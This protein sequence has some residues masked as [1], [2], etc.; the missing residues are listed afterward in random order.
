MIDEFIER[1]GEV[2]RIFRYNPK[3]SVYFKTAKQ[4]VAILDTM[5][6]G[7]T[8]FLDG[9]LQSSERDEEI[10]HRMLVHPILGT[11]RETMKD[12]LVIGGGEG[13]TL[14]EILK[15]KD[16]GSVTMLDWDKE[17]I[18]YFREK[19][20]TWHRG[21]FEDPR[22]KLEFSDIF[23]VI[24]ET[25]KYDR[26]Y[27]DLV[28]PDLKDE[29]WRNFFQKLVGWL[30]PKGAM[31]INAGGVFPWDEGDVPEIERILGESIGKNN[32]ECPYQILRMK[33]FVPSFGREWAFVILKKL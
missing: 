27:V 21:A 18:T 28:D 8:L 9:I 31:N 1:D 17:L 10:Y 24:G 13:A 11:D 15:W 7:R 26:I 16:V 33:K 12:V 32:K 5:L 22:V 2:I 30:N 25:R 19:E 4:D 3:T 20:P 6:F 23:D 29:R 14:R